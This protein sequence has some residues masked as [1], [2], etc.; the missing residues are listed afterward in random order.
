[1]VEDSPVSPPLPLPTSA[2]GTG[3]WATCGTYYSLLQ[4][5]VTPAEGFAGQSVG[6]EEYFSCIG[7]AGDSLPLVLGKV[8][9]GG[10]SP[11]SVEAG[12][13]GKSL[14][15]LETGK[16]RGPDISL[17]QSQAQGRNPSTAQSKV[18]EIPSLCAGQSVWG[19]P[20][21]WSQVGGESLPHWSRGTRS[22]DFPCTPGST[23]KK[24]PPCTWIHGREGVEMGILHHWDAAADRC[25][26]GKK[27]CLLA[28]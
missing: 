11:S 25:L 26:V 6:W 15:W 22:Q 10:K 14:S 19:N 2:T 23:R 12:M 8:L 28:F 16:Q 21:S 5:W 18:L 17:L 13:Q 9:S 3:G 4:S 27:H 24:F 20:P 7:S 1:M